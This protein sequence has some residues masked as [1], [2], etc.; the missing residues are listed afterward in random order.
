MATQ[1]RIV[2]TD[3]N[4]AARV[5]AKKLLKEPSLGKR[6]VL[7]ELGNKVLKNVEVV[8]GKES[9]IFKP[10]DPSFKHVKARVDTHW[11]KSEGTVTVHPVGKPVTR[12]D[13]IR[14]LQNTGISAAAAAAALKQ[15]NV[16]KTTASI[17]PKVVHVTKGNEVK[18]VKV[19]NL[20]REESRLNRR[21]LTKLKQI[22]KQSDAS[23]T[24]SSERSSEEEDFSVQEKLDSPETHSHKLLEG[25]ENI[26][27]NDA[28]NPMLVSDY[29]NDIYD[30]LNS[31]E[32][33]FAIRENFLDGHK[34]INHKMRTILIDW[35]NEV[36]YQFKLE[37]DTYHMTVSI[38]DR[39]LQLVADTPKKELQLVGVTAMFIASKYEEMFPP[40]I[41]DFAYITDDTYKKK[42]ILEMEKQIVK[43]LDFH[44]G[45]PL[46]TH[47]L[48]RFS[49]AAK[50][51]D[52]NHLVAKYIIEL[53]SIDYSTAHYKPSEIA[54]AAL[55]ISLH[56]FPLANNETKIWNKTIEHY[57]GYTV[58]SMTP[59]VQRLAKVVKNAPNLKVQAVYIKYQ[60]SKFEKIS[61]QPELQSAALEAF[62]EGNLKP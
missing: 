10:A 46:P 48:R 45:K 49:K 41:S 52:K 16:A 23:S 19:V 4:D 32:D 31:L 13:S 51:A 12:A 59:V 56:L 37:I 38:I 29:V 1:F 27:I 22:R 5:Q 21:S 7:G 62:I 47:F 58:E 25:I 30:Y 61:I 9:A 11:K 57:T 54:A 40:D 42:Q 33:V 43:V 14:V 34:Q 2:K 24:T 60:S 20:K 8:K 39:Y 44:L 15:T 35:I 3:E 28:W 6:A 50:A 36:H 53:A 17:K 55:Y 26:D 18:K